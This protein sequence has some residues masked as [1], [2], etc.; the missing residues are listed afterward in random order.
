MHHAQCMKQHADQKCVNQKC[1]ESLYEE[2][3][4]GLKEQRKRDKKVYDK[5]VNSKNVQDEGGE[6]CLVE[7]EKKDTGEV[8]EKK[9]QHE[10]PSLKSKETSKALFEHISQQKAKLNENMDGFSKQLDA[11]QKTRK[12]VKDNFSYP[13]QLGIQEYAEK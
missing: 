3:Y 10:Y 4:K 12:N 9:P 13:L 8:A 2:L 5:E 6:S 7:E 1:K 11:K